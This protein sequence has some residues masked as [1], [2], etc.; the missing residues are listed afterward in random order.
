MR[1]CSSEVGVGE[2]FN[3]CLR[4]VSSSGVPSHSL[5]QQC[6]ALPMGL[7]VICAAGFCFSAR[8][9]STAWPLAPE[10]ACAEGASPMASAA[11]SPQPNPAQPG[12]G[13]LPPHPHP[14][15]GATS[16]GCWCG[17]SLSLLNVGEE[18]D[19]STQHVVNRLQPQHHGP[20]ALA[21]LR[22][23]SSCT[24]ASRQTVGERPGLHCPKPLSHPAS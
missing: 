3:G 12:P 13:P 4:Q 11:E 20:K 23:N 21:W 7:L 24:H 15:S 14:A 17:V 9:S 19:T 22:G 18:V 8:G 6:L 5:T 1:H 10:L 16:K 2:R